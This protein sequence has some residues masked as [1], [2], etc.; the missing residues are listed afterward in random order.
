L[1]DFFGV[2]RDHACAWAVN[3]AVAARAQVVRVLAGFDD[4]GEVWINGEPLALQYTEHAD[5]WLA[6]SEEATIA[7]EEGRNTVAIRTCEDTGDW[8]FYF[9]MV[10]PDGGALPDVRWEY[11]GRKLKAKS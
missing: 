7:L 10:A 8:R 9:R 1:N 6:D 4:E 11:G 2:D 3:F 5:E